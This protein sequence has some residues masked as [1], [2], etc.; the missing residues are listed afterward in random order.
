MANG[1]KISPKIGSMRAVAA[2]DFDRG[3]K[4][5]PDAGKNLKPGHLATRGG[6]LDK[7]VRVACNYQVTVEDPKTRALQ[8]VT[9]QA[10]PQDR[11]IGWLT[12]GV[13]GRGGFNTMK[14]NDSSVLKCEGVAYKS[15]W[16]GGAYNLREI[17][18]PDGARSFD[19]KKVPALGERILR[20]QQTGETGN[21]PA[22]DA[23]NNPKLKR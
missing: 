18:L 21:T 16:S 20:F 17:S 9:F 14:D 3:G 11:G 10:V 7:T 13:S 22:F 12:S 2:P 6:W 1:P 5:Y 15:V 4:T 23:A 19:V 8:K